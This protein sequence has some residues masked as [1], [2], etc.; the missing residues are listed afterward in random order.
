LAALLGAAALALTR[1]TARRV[2]AAVVGAIGLVGG[3]VVAAGVLRA[4]SAPGALTAAPGVAL[5][6]AVL[7]VAGAVS[8]LRRPSAPPTLDARYT[9]EGDADDDEWRLADAEDGDDAHDPGGQRR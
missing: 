3:V 6:G 7:V 4:W 8:G 5:A 9:V 2:A 1:G